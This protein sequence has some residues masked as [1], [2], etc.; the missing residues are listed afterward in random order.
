MAQKRLNGGATGLIRAGHI[1]E[2]VTAPCHRMLESGEA[3]R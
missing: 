1:V 2:S 3:G